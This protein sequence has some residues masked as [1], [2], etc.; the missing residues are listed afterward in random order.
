MQWFRRLQS[1]VTWL[2]ALDIRKEVHFGS[3][4]EDTAHHGGDD[5]MVRVVPVWQQEWEV[6]FTLDLKSGT[7]KVT[8]ADVTWLNFSGN[9]LTKVCLLG[10]SPS[11][12]L[13]V[14]I[15]HHRSTSCGTWLPL[16]VDGTLNRCEEKAMCACL[17]LP[18]LPEL[19]LRHCSC[20]H[21]PLTP[22]SSLASCPMLT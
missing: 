3:Q 4:L 6:W 10:D 11:A 13:T 18:L 17:P 19:C 14:K 7:K 8:N 1:I 9:V 12:K 20:C 5:M 22:R 21:L 15:S 2:A 16:K